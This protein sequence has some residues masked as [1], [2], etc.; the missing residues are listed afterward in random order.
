MKEIIDNYV[1]L[2]FNG[3]N[4]AVVK[5]CQFEKNYKP[6][7]PKDEKEKVLDVG[8]GRGEM[9][10]CMKEWGY[11]YNGVDISKSTV[12]YCNGLNL[13][14]E[15]TDNSTQWLKDRSGKYKVVTCL[16]VLEHIDREE[17]IKFLSAIRE[18]LVAGGV[19]I[20]QVPNL[21]SP[22]G[23]LHHF[24]DVTHRVGY[25]EH[26]LNQVLLASGFKKIIFFGLEELCE[27]NVK[28]YIRRVFRPFFHFSIRVLR[29]INSNPNPKILHPVLSVVAYKE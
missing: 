25:V 9:L 12:E 17:S 10:A 26:S 5:F 22:F 21:Q 29:F 27:H 8:I 6:F 20:I 18:S 1:D 19:A 14:C 24:N 4:Q 13:S 15:Q 23:Y 7:F 2:S 28:T 11:N 16:D 3:S